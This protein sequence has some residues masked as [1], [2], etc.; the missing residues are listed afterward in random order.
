MSPEKTK[1]L[2]FF[3]DEYQFFSSVLTGSRSPSETEWHSVGR[4]VFV[5]SA[6]TPLSAPMSLSRSTDPAV[7]TTPCMHVLAQGPCAHH[8]WR[9]VE[10]LF[11][12][13]FLFFVVCK[14][15]FYC[16]FCLAAILLMDL[17]CNLLTVSLQWPRE[18]IWYTHFQLHRV[19][20]FFFICGSNFTT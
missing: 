1:W 7:S 15:I 9:A 3:Q 8:C 14:G 16:L 12:I 17:L 19:V 13:Y 18:K 11:F 4:S 2:L 10:V 6:P 5:S 20:S